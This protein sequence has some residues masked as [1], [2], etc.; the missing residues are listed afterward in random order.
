MLVRT[1][2]LLRIV[3]APAVGD[4]AGGGGGI[5]NNGHPDTNNKLLKTHN[6]SLK[7]HLSCLVM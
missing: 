3:Q 2:Q 6:Y 5:N 1:G 4:L 7:F